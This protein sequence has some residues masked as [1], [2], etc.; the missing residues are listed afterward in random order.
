MRAAVRLMRSAILAALGLAGAGLALAGGATSDI[1]P[2]LRLVAHWVLD[3]H[4]NQGRPFAIVDK[5]AAQVRVYAAD[6][7][8]LGSSAA[9]LGLATGDKA[10]PDIARRTPAS[11]K[12][13]ERTTP[14]GRYETQPGRN[15]HGEDIVWLDY[16]ASLALHRLRPAPAAEHR[17]ERLASPAA[18][19]NRISLGCVVV[20]VA[21]YE[22]VVAPVLGRERAVVYILPE[23]EPVRGYF[24][25][26]AL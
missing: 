5:K 21:F 18:S 7:H 12:P 11:L 9:L 23:D 20:P 17:A 14:A 13:F 22:R 26:R 24:E 25:S 1:T 10:T 6:G 19:D 15:L 3:T 8:L 4:D 16:A 2:E